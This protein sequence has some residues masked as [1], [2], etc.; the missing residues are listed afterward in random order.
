MNGKDIK[1]YML[2]KNFIVLPLEKSQIYK[3]R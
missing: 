3:K 1:I 2:S